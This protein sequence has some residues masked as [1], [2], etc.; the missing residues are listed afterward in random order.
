MNYTAH[1]LDGPSFFQGLVKPV[2]EQQQRVRKFH[3]IRE[4]RQSIE[5][6]PRKHMNNNITRAAP[7]AEAVVGN[8][9]LIKEAIN[10]SHA[11]GHHL[12]LA[13]DRLAGP[14]KVIDV[15]RERLGFV[16]QLDG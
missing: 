8:L 1:F 9:V 14:W 6:E 13:P 11:D 4:E 3:R 5:T 12:K 10:I 15:I 7:G 16:V 2:A